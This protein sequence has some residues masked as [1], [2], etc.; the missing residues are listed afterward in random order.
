MSLVFTALYECRIMCERSKLKL[1]RFYRY[2][3][4]PYDKWFFNE[5]FDLFMVKI[6]IYLF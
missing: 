3:M 1:C 2:F 6:G 5:I 4:L